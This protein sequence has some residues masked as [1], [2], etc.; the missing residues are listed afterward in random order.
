MCIKDYIIVNQYKY[1]QIVLECCAH[2]SLT[3]QPSS[4]TKSMTTVCPYARV[5]DPDGR[6]PDPVPDPT[7]W[8]KTDPNPTLKKKKNRI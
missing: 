6:C 5:A 1:V 8:K 2:I 7:F 3:A 4:Y